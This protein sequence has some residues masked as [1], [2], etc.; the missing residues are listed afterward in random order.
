M[1]N[2]GGGGGGGG[3]GVKDD[4]VYA[5]S[6]SVSLTQLLFANVYQNQNYNMQC[7]TNLYLWMPLINLFRP[8]C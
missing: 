2:L 1:R 4:L 3:G 6:P 8:F 5:L 7:S